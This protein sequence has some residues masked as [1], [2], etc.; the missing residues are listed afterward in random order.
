MKVLVTG[1]GAHCALGDNIETLWAAIEQ[2]K[3]GISPITNR[4]NVAQFD[5]QLG[6]MVP[7]GDK[8]DSEAQRLLAYGCAAAS[9]ALQ[10]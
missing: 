5:T 7:S 3:S 10:R 2:G 1:L 4:F 8:Y 6:A 9:E